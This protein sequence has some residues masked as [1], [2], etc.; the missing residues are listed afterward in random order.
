MS[1]FHFWS[2]SHCPLASHCAHRKGSSPQL[3][4]LISRG[5]ASPVRD[6][7][8][9]TQK[10]FS[11]MC[12]KRLMSSQAEPA[13]KMQ[14]FLESGGHNQKALPPEAA[15]PYPPMFHILVRRSSSPLLVSHMRSL[16]VSAPSPAS[17]TTDKIS[18]FLFLKLRK[19]NSTLKA[20]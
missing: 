3:W 7:S 12:W 20:Y 14:L 11:D 19:Q 16:Q 5:A 1:R 8:E 2:N 10:V 17:E 6:S 4:L 13:I 18:V 9:N 15:Q